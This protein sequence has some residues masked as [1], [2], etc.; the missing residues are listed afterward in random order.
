MAKTPPSTILTEG[1]GHEHF[2]TTDDC[3]FSPLSD[4]TSKMRDTAFANIRLRAGHETRGE[5]Y[6]EVT[7]DESNQQVD[8]CD[9]LH[10]AQHPESPHAHSSV[11]F[12][13]CLVKTKEVLPAPDKITGA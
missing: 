3:A 8:T 12:R 6:P 9:E 13:A 2:G 4:D 11:Y 1:L 5:S 10:E 7:C